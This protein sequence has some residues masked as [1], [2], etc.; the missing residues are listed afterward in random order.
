MAS[1]TVKGHIQN[2]NQS[3]FYIEV[4]DDDQHW[5]DDRIDDLL[6]SSWTDDSGQ[7]EIIFDDTLFKDN[8][9]EGRPELF[10]IV[11]DASGKILHKTS[12]KKPSNPDDTENLNF[13]ITIPEQDY[14]AENSYD[15]VNARRMAAFTQIGDSIDLADNIGNSSQLLIQS[16]NAWLLYTNEAK[17]NLIGY[18]GPQVERYPWRNPHTHKLKWNK[19]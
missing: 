5:F 4:L 9:F 2:Y 16:L 14:F 12:P 15:S 17:W 13:E 19:H 10:L 8:W 1:Y 6:G 18:D 11:R 3:K 7:F